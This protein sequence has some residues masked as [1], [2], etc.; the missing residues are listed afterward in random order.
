MNFQREW[1]KPYARTGQRMTR[2]T[3]AFYQYVLI[4]YCFIH[5]CVRLDFVDCLSLF[6]CRHCH[7]NRFCDSGYLSDV[8]ARTSSF[9]SFWSFFRCFFVIVL[10]MLLHGRSLCCFPRDR[11]SC[12]FPRDASMWCIFVFVL[13]DA[14]FMILLFDRSS[15][16]V[17]ITVLIRDASLWWF[18]VMLLRDA[19]SSLSVYFLLTLSTFLTFPIFLTS[20]SIMLFYNTHYFHIF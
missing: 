7:Y 6:V 2:T 20:S 9:D 11:S 14:F 16:S 15:W 4:C 3:K 17:F 19:S 10:Q 5:S 12:C 8:A 13:L 1:K 18:F